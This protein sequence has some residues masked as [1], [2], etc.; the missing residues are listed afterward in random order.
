MLKNFAG[1]FRKRNSSCDSCEMFGAMKNRIYR[2]DTRYEK[3]KSLR[4][5]ILI[6]SGVKGRCISLL[7]DH[8]FV[9]SCTTHLVIF[10]KRITQKWCMANW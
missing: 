6:T 9:V 7:N 10:Y 3:K 8:P 5:L 1:G 2:D 4:S